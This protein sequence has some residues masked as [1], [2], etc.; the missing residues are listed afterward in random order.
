MIILLALIIVG[1]AQYAQLME[2]GPTSV[3]SDQ[4]ARLAPRRYASVWCNKNDVFIYGGDT[5]S[6]GNGRKRDMW[7][8]EGE[9]RRWIWFPDGPGVDGRS[10]MAHWN[11]Y[12]R[13]WMYGGRTDAGVT[14]NDLWSYTLADRTWHA[15]SIAPTGP[16]PRYGSIYWV[17][18]LTNRIFIYGGNGGDVAVDRSI[19][20]F[21]VVT[22]TWTIHDNSAAPEAITPTALYGS[23]FTQVED[24]VYILTPANTF[25]MLNTNTLQWSSLSVLNGPTIRSNGVLFPTATRDQLVLFGG[26]QGSQMYRDMWRYDTDSDTWQELN[27]GTRPSARFG[28]SVCLDES[29]ASYSFGGSFNDQMD[30]DIWRYGSKTNIHDIVSQIQFNLDSATIFSLWSA[31]VGTLALVFLIT[32]SIVMCVYRCKR[33]R[34]NTLT[35][36][37]TNNR[38]GDEDREETF[39]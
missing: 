11:L 29:G 26:F 2:N 19:W 25:W 3:T 9:T 36:P 24:R 38:G 18:S 17:D 4:S 33:R 28:S 21:D 22:N 37:L 5:G 13:F 10:E 31:I 30:N 32:L 12:G 20:A 35:G 7:K 15:S 1:S 27:D 34:K 39:L 16:G 8:F 14:L 6:G 23:Q